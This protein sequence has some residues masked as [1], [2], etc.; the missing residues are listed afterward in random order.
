M[1]EILPYSKWLRIQEMAELST[2]TPEQ[3]KYCYQLVPKDKRCLEVLDIAIT[4]SQLERTDLSDNYLKY[5]VLRD[6]EGV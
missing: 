1:K 6:K 5:L 3:L 2:Y 4:V